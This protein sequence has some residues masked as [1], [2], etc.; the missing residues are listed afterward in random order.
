MDLR[1]PIL[2]HCFDEAVKDVRVHHCCHQLKTWPVSGRETIV[3]P[4]F[5]AW[6][7]MLEDTG[8]ATGFC[9][10]AQHKQPVAGGHGSLATT[11]SVTLLRRLTIVRFLLFILRVRTR[12]PDRFDLL[13]TGTVWKKTAI[14][15]QVSVHHHDH[16]A[17]AKTGNAG[18]P[19]RLD[20]DI[21][22]RTAVRPSGFVVWTVDSGRTAVVA[23]PISNA[24]HRAFP[25]TRTGLVLGI[26]LGHSHARAPPSPPL[27]SSGFDEFALWT[28]LLHHLQL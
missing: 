26:C 16:P 7:T 12:C 23:E 8:V 5:W 27:L 6:T 4:V 24:L 20:L 11:A 25:R 1:C 28:S 17:P 22:H 10:A 14:N 19:H 15:H 9:S 2:I 21:S 3:R 13:S 18:P